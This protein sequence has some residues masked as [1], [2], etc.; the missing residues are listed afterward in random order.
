MVDLTERLLVDIVSVGLGDSLSAAPRC[1]MAFRASAP[2][3]IDNLGQTRSPMTAGSPL[4][5]P[6]L[7]AQPRAPKVAFGRHMEEDKVH[8]NVKLTMIFVN[9]L[10]GLVAAGS[11][12]P[13]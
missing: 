4:P 1:A 3:P 13:C 5:L 8:H 11:S 12:N 10:H 6:L 7:S 9:I 2:T